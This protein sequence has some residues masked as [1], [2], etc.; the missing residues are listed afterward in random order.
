MKVSELKELISGWDDSDELCVLIWDK[1]LFDFDED[2][3]LTDEG[4][5]NVVKA[6]EENDVASGIHQSLYDA[7]M[8]EAEIVHPYPQDRQDREEVQ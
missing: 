7:A 8:D 4:W 5:S 2:L 6:F 1:S 3:V